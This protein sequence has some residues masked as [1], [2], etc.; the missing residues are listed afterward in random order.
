[1]K[2]LIIPD[3]QVKEGDPVD[4]LEALGNYIV[5]KKPDRIIM[6]GDWFDMPSMSQYEERQSAYFEG[7]SYRADID[8]GIHAMHVLMNPICRYN[9]RRKLNHKKGY[10]PEYTFLLGNHEYRIHRAVHRDPRL[11][12]LISYDDLELEFYGWTV[13]EFLH[14]VPIDGVLYSH[15][16][17]NQNTLNKRILGGAIENRIKVIGHSFT[18]GHQQTRMYGSVYTALGHERKGL[19]CGAFYQHDEDYAGPQGSNYWRG[20][21]MKH[22]VHD[23]SYDPMFVS[24]NYLLKN[25]L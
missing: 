6:L 24:I 20:V 14:I 21:V 23:G 19:V 22:E 3:T 7:K 17:V 16:F 10:H 5:A 9:D 12:G 18:M 1:M 2:H 8:S 15:Y 4:H 11:R 13:H 25:W